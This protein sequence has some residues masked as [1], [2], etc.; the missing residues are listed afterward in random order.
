VNH[1]AENVIIRR[2]LGYGFVVVGAVLAAYGLTSSTMGVAVS[3][4]GA[5]ALGIIL[6][7]IKD[8][9]RER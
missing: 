6:L 8:Q 5:T 7:S 4:F 2:A 9:S 3:G 1:A